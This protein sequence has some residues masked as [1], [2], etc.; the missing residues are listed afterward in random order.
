MTTKKTTKAVKPSAPVKPK[1]TKMVNADG[2]TADVHPNEV[3]NY[4]K[5]GFKCLDMKS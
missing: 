5:G 3:A 4:E 1:L 2:K